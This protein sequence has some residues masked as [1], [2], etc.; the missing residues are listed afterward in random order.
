MTSTAAKPVRVA[1]AMLGPCS[2]LTLSSVV[3]TLSEANRQSGASLYAVTVYRPSW[4][5]PMQHTSAW[6]ANLPRLSEPPACDWLWVLADELS[7]PSDPQP[8][9]D[10]LACAGSKAR[11]V[12]CVAQGAWWLATAGLL[13]GYA[14]SVHTSLYD[15]FIH[16]FDVILANQRLFDIDRSRASS[17]GGLATVDLL[18]TLLTQRH[19]AVLADRVAYALNAAPTRTRQTLQ[20]TTGLSLAARQEPR[21]MEALHLMETNLAEPLST[22]ETA[23]L[24]GVSRR[25]LERLFHLYLHTQP[26]A[27]YLELRLGHAYTLLQQTSR[28]IAQIAREAGFN[29]A[30]YFSYAYRRRF[31]Q[32]PGDLRKAQ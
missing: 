26:A 19:G 20:A 28:P 11:L 15:R 16:D 22:E 6:L 21:L 12:A 2:L 25:H 13:D 24:V 18:L 7:L 9:A 27:W 10:R 5:L 3:D 31:N 14:V 8:T 23:R 29:S 4:P 17:A 30:Q 1:V 32:R